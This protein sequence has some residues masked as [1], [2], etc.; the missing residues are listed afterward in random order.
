[1][2]S[3]TVIT[4][5]AVLPLLLLWA[6]YVCTALVAHTDTRDEGQGRMVWVLLRPEPIPF[7]LE[8]RRG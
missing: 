7:R 6:A 8:V 2:T 1:M 4:L 3:E 5:I